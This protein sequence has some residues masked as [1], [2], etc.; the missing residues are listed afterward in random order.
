MNTIDLRL[1]LKFTAAGDVQTVDGK[2]LTI[3]W[4]QRTL[5]AEPGS[6]PFWPTWGV[7]VETHAGVNEIAAR[8]SLAARIRS[9]LT[10]SEGIDSVTVGMSPGGTG[11]LTVSVSVALASGERATVSAEVP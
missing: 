2:E 5:C 10:L 6:T 8:A 4:A 11:R 7:G 9:Q 3:D 1:P